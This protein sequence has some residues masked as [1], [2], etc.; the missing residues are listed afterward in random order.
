MF[1]PGIFFASN[2]KI[3]QQ[4]VQHVHHEFDTVVECIVDF[5][6]SLILDEPNHNLTLEQVN[7]YGCHSVFGRSQVGNKWEFVV[8]ES[9]RT[10]PIKMF[11]P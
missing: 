9:S 11:S 10:K 2:P 5:G 4:K 6:D 8:F 1:G 3:A 7:Q